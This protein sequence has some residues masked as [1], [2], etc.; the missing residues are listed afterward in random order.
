VSEIIVLECCRDPFFLGRQ[1]ATGMIG[2]KHTEEDSAAEKEKKT[3]ANAAYNGFRA[4]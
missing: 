3:A 1:W 4:V 2:K